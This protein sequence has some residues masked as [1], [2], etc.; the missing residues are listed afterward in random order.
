M[1]IRHFYSCPPSKILPQLLLITAPNI[2]KLLI[3]QKAVLFRKSVPLSK[4]GEEETMI[5]VMIFL[6]RFCAN[7]EEIGLERNYV[8][9]VDREER[10]IPLGNI[11]LFKLTERK[12]NTTS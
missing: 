11:S 10:E 12:E 8:N 7:V 6:S 9:K 5:T 4:K 1:E 2:K 3:S